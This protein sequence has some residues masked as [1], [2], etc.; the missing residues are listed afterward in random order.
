MAGVKGGSGRGEGVGDVAA[1]ASIGVSPSETTSGLAQLK[2]V[3]SELL[4]EVGQLSSTASDLG[5]SGSIA[6]HLSAE[7]VVVFLFH[8]PVDSFRVDLTVC[9]EELLSSIE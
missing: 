9:K 1:E 7:G 6:D 4:S 2:L 3:I 5:T 8:S